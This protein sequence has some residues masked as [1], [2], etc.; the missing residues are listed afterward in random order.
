MTNCTNWDYIQVRDFEYLTN[1]WHNEVENINVK[2][3][4]SSYGNSLKNALDLE[5]ADL[6]ADASKF[7]KAVHLNQYRSGIG[8]LEKE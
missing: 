6:D 8:F 4:I 5:I 3:A 7:F 2:D 1:L